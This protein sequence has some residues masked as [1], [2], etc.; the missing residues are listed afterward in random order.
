LEQDKLKK[1]LVFLQH[2][3]Q[4]RESELKNRQGNVFLVSVS[5]R[6]S[7]VGNTLFSHLTDRINQ[8]ELDAST[9]QTERDDAVREKNE[10]FSSCQAQLAAEK[11][12]YD[13][14]L[15]QLKERIDHLEKS[16]ADHND[17][18]DQEIVMHL[19]AARDLWGREY[20][21]RHPSG[22][23]SFMQPID[24]IDH[25]EEQINNDNH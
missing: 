9:Y 25:V 13:A 22:D 6:L 16:L 1:E 10:M 14:G 18:T 19:E 12:K 5:D 23:P 21:R 2:V 7:N 20:S 24:V 17:A 15:T 11:Q 4:A 8:L 3:L